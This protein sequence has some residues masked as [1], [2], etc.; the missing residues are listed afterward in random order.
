MF[1]AMAN[2][3]HAQTISGTFREAQEVGIQALA[4]HAVIVKPAL[5][6]VLSAL[7]EDGFLVVN[8][9]RRHADGIAWGNRPCLIGPTID[10]RLVGRDAGEPGWDPV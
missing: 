5:R 2:L 6:D 1:L 4:H 3:L 9:E 8:V 7:R 10:H